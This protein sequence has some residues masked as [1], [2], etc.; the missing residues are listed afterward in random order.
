M[1]ELDLGDGYDVTNPLMPLQPSAVLTDSSGDDNV[2]GQ[3]ESVG[4]LF[5]APARADEDNETEK[6]SPSKLELA[7]ARDIFKDSS[8]EEE[9]NAAAD[10]IDEDAASTDEI[11]VVQKVLDICE[12]LPGSRCKSGCSYPT[13]RLP[14]PYFKVRWLNYGSNDDSWEPDSG[15]DGCRGIVNDFM[16]MHNA[17]NARGKRGQETRLKKMN[18]RTREENGGRIRVGVHRTSKGSQSM[19]KLREEHADLIAGS[20]VRSSTSAS[21]ESSAWSGSDTSDP[22]LSSF[23]TTKKKRKKKEKKIGKQKSLLKKGDKSSRSGGGGGKQRA[24][25]TLKVGGSGIRS[26]ASSPFN[27][28]VKQRRQSYSSSSSLSSAAAS[29]AKV[30]RKWAAMAAS[31]RAVSGGAAA[32]KGESSSSNPGGDGKLL[33][34]NSVSGGLARSAAAAVFEEGVPTS[35]C[36]TLPA[37]TFL[38]AELIKTAVVRRPTSEEDVSNSKVL[39]SQTVRLL[40]KLH[41]TTEMLPPAVVQ[42]IALQEMQPSAASRSTSVGEFV[43]HC[44]HSQTP[45]LQG[46]SRRLFEMWTHRLQEGSACTGRRCCDRHVADID[47]VTSHPN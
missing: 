31:P 13:V 38:I 9:A 28:K 41:I 34:G 18:K 27:K 29:A 22:L 1:N 7:R 35:G 20:G 40:L 5:A 46:A 11:F 32:G 26:F 10:D 8:D 39:A 3:S 42:E 4:N 45:K 36:I 2:D 21:S 15:M 25:S 19:K 30:K 43:R 6:P 37:H 44:M 33:E 12:G 16:R 23:E 24:G 17:M 47:L 14:H